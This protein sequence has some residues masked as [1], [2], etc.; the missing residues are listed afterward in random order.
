MAKNQ[1]FESVALL[2]LPHHALEMKS[3]GYRLAQ[4]CCTKK[5]HFILLYSFVKDATLVNL[6]VILPYEQEIASITGI[7]PYA[8]LY[9]NEMKDLF[10]VHVTG[11]NVDFRG[12]FYTTRG[13]TPFGP[14][15]S[16]KAAS[17]ETAQEAKTETPA[18]EV[19]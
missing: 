7:Y 5:E 12:H 9:E 16:E 6:E 14:S 8:Y 10:G 19:E 17:A 15:D 11:M 13:A 2:E 18:K 1:T 4:I 3:G